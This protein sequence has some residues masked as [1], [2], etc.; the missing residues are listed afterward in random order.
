MPR[1]KTRYNN[2]FNSA[3]PREIFKVLEGT[4]PPGAYDYDKNN[5]GKVP[6]KFDE[7]LGNLDIKTAPFNSN[8]PRFSYR[9]IINFEVPNIMIGY[10]DK[11]KMTEESE[12]GPGDQ[13][14]KKTINDLIKKKKQ[15]VVP[16]NSN[17]ILNVVIISPK[18]MTR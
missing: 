17:V 10:L 8:K 16:F 3:V 15:N 6:P 5:V 1:I 9:M 12:K 2:C 14:N 11:P 18:N 13:K 7:D 4:P